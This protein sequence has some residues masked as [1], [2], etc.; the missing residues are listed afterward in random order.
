MRRRLMFLLVI[1]S[2]VR[3]SLLD[4]ATGLHRGSREF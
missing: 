1:A 4:H 3:A 2:A